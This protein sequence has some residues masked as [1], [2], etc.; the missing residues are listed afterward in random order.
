MTIVGGFDVHRAQITFDYVDCGT[1]EVSSGRIAPADREVLRE[2]LERRFAGRAECRVRLG[3][4]HGMAVCG[5]RA[6]PGRD[7]GACR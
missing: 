1:G 2:W 5:R 3:G 7:R 6:R 4:V